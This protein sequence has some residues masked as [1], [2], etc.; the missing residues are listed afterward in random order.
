MAEPGV[1]W[2]RLKQSKNK[3]LDSRIGTLRAS[4]RHTNLIWVCRWD[5]AEPGVTWDRLMQNKN[6]E[7]DRLNGIYMKMLNNAGVEYFEG[8]GTI[9]DAH[10]VEVDGK[11]YTV[12]AE[13][14]SANN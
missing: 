6:K 13:Y 8:R 7:L 1:T 14:Q 5:V 10:T 3:E 11:K 12:S 2:D 9:V 4:V